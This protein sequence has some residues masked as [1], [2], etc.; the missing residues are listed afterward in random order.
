LS[1][2]VILR[3]ASQALAAA[4]SAAGRPQPEAVASPFPNVDGA[5]QVATEIAR[6]GT[7]VALGPVDVVDLPD[8]NVIGA[9]G[10]V[11][12]GVAVSAGFVAD[13]ALA[14]GLVPSRIGA[15]CLSD[16]YISRASTAGAS[17]AIV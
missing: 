10:V 8:T 11:V 4:A 1:N 9:V 5:S 7:T 15:T 2:C 12:G 6:R 3:W 14:A 13:D 17:G 16:I